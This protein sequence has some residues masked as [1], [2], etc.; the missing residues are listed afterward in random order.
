MLVHL[1]V[2]IPGPPPRTKRG[3]EALLH[4]LIDRM[5]KPLAL[6][7]GK[8]KVAVLFAGDVNRPD[9]ALTKIEIKTDA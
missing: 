5:E 7:R 6:H 4:H 3:G 8:V 9:P 2:E 1:T